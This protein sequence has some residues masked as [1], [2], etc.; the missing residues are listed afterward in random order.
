M[1]FVWLMLTI[2]VALV[3]VDVA[4]RKLLG[5]KRAKLT[6]P[7]G[8]KI[9][10]LGRIICVI[11][12]FITYPAVI[13]T[14]VLQIEHLFVIFFTVLFC[15]QAIIQYLYIKESKEFIITLLMNVVFVV[16][17]LNIDSLLKL[18]S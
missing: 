12:V 17:L 1:T 2:A 7:K 13:E 3:F 9:D 4:V 14:G 6:D 5:I 15:L 11:L 8:K 16:F 18:Y 10:V